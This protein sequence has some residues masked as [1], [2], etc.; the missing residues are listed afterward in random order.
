MTQTK[1]SISNSPD[2]LVSIAY[3]SHKHGNSRLKQMAVKELLDRFGI[4]LTFVRDA[5]RKEVSR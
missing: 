1:Q 2:A 3:G 4:R 5:S